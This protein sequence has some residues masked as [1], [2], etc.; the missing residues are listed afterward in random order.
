MTLSTGRRLLLFGA[1]LIALIGAIYLRSYLYR[2]SMPPIS[3]DLA[4]V[5]L[6]ARAHPDDPTAQIA[7]G[8]AL[9]L[10]NHPN[11]AMQVFA[12][13]AQRWPHDAR[14]YIGLG[15]L[16]LQQHRDAIAQVNFEQAVRCDPRNALV[17]HLLGEVY[18]RRHEPL[19][20]IHAYME[21][22]KLAPNDEVAWRQLGVL[23]TKRKLYAAGYAALQRAT[24]LNPKDARAQ[25]D[26]GNIALVQG[27]LAIA[28][29]AFTKALQLQPH[30]PDALIGLANANMLLDSS[31]SGLANDL[32]LIQQIADPAHNAIACETRGHIYL[33]Q[34]RYLLAI[35]SLQEAIRANPRRTTAYVLLS[36][37]YAAVGNAQAAEKAAKTYQQL[38]QTEGADETAPPVGMGH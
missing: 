20:A 38:L 23:E 4:T 2:H 15:A 19:A 21:A 13:A 28:Q 31:P 6:Y 30:A 7:W 1:L 9:M 5:G 33:L 11:Q 10:H 22:T 26:F 16:A 29:Q 24:A 12:D 34:R 36:Q 32:S 14:P 8:N 37:A 35:K 27:Q 17:W 18:E 3:N 25:I